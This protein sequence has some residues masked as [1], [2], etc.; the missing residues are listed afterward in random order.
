[1]MARRKPSGGRTCARTTPTLRRR[2]ICAAR[3]IGRNRTD[4]LDVRGISLLA[5]ALHP[6][7]GESCSVE[8]DSPA[9]RGTLGF[10]SVG[11]HEKCRRAQGKEYS[12]A[13]DRHTTCEKRSD[14][15][16]RFDPRTSRAVDCR[17]DR[18]SRAQLCTRATQMV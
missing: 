8:W 1:M 7:C 16:D 11:L 12:N 17:S 4:S 5:V 10:E 18:L 13:R 14:S 9:W 2:S 6:G 15:H 3:H